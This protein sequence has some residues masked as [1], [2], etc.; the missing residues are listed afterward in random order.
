MRWS[1]RWWGEVIGDVGEHGIP[2]RVLHLVGG[3]A[4]GGVLV[5]VLDLIDLLLVIG[6]LDGRGGGR[7]GREC[8]GGWEEAGVLR[9]GPS[10]DSAASRNGGGGGGRSGRGVFLVGVSDD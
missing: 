4:E 1:G 8:V 10:N 6:D 7:R 9:R 5:G 2:I 3:V